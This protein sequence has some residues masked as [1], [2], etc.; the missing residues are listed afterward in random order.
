[1]SQAN[2]TLITTRAKP[3]AGSAA[4]KKRPAA[5]LTFI[6][7]ATIMNASL[8]AE[9]LLCLIEAHRNAYEAYC[10]AINRE[11]ELDAA[12]AQGQRRGYRSLPAWWGVI[13][14][15]PAVTSVKRASLL[16]SIGNAIT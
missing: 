9:E 8:G 13:H 10:K 15:A 1:M 7:P 3:L 12:Y 4:A 6:D 2:D 5:T 14:S 16:L 11:Q